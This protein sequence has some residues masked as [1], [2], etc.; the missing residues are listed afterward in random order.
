M[1]ALS[2]MPEVNPRSRIKHITTHAVSNEICEIW[3]AFPGVRAI[4]LHLRGA[5]SERPHYHIWCEFETELKNSEVKD[6]LRAHNI[7]FAPPFQNW[8]FTVGNE[9]IE[10]F[11]AWSNYVVDAGKGSVVLYETPDETHPKLPELPVLPPASGAS[12]AAATLSV[13][14]SAS[15][16]APQR[17]R[18]VN[19][20]KADLN[21]E[22]GTIK[23]WNIHE[24]TEE[25]INEL[26]EWSEN[27]FT[28][29]NGAV[30]IQHAL[31]VFSDDV[32]RNYLKTKNVDAVRKSIR[33]FS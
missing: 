15:S 23:Q 18:F 28:T 14:S 1:W 8:K 12:S 11:K 21:W 33:L 19:Y 26:T 3:K 22:P 24:K 30:M 16:R 27:A 32:A 2:R 31:W 9:G 10:H 5:K 17:V 6:Q 25:L 29:P 13:R 7:M 20:L 4:V